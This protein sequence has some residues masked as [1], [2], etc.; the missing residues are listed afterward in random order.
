MHLPA[1]EPRSCN[2]RQSYAWHQGQ[3]GPCR[4]TPGRAPVCLPLSSTTT[5]FTT[6]YSTLGILVRL[7]ECRMIRDSAG[8]KHSQISGHARPQQ[9]PVKNPDFDDSRTSSSA[10][11]PAKSVSAPAHTGPE[12]AGTSVVAWMW[13][14]RA[15]APSVATAV[16]SEPMETN[17]CLSAYCMSSSNDENKP[18]VQSPGYPVA[19]GTTHLLDSAQ[20]ADHIVHPPALKLLVC[21][22]RKTHQQHP[23]PTASGRVVVVQ[24]DPGIRSQSRAPSAA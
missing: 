18:W 3:T 1:A 8:I 20:I 22:I 5:P 6:T 11:P 4:I 7:V 16:P 15:R 9:A 23:F 12:H 14:P 21:R 13:I 17:G 24:F 2:T 19:H 10:P